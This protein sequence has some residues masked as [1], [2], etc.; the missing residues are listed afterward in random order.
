MPKHDY[1]SAFTGS[2]QEAYK[3]AAAAQPD[4][5]HISLALLLPNFPLK[6]TVPLEAPEG[7]A[8]GAVPLPVCL[9]TGGAAVGQ[10]SRA[11]TR[12]V[13]VVEKVACTITA[14]S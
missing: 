6:D 10:A 14:M 3:R 8:Q 11:H 5:R 2:L 4:M 12:Q 13:R 9:G 1:P 7:H